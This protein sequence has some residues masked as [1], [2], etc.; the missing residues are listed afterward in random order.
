MAQDLEWPPVSEVVLV[1]VIGEL[2]EKGQR[3]I[4]LNLKAVNRSGT[5]ELVRK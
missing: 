5:G 1:D 3:K 2:A 4:L